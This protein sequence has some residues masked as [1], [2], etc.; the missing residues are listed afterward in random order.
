M[1][2]KSRLRML[3]KFNSLHGDPAPLLPRQM[4]L[5]DLMNLRSGV[6][7]RVEEVVKA[8]GKRH[9]KRR[10][11]EQLARALD[12]LSRDTEQLLEE[13]HFGHHHDLESG[14]YGFDG[15]RRWRDTLADALSGPLADDARGP[16]HEAA[17]RDWYIERAAYAFIA[18]GYTGLGAAATSV[19]ASWLRLLTGIL[20]FGDTDA[21]LGEIKYLNKAVGR[22]LGRTRA[23]RDQYE[24]R[25]RERILQRRSRLPAKIL[26]A[27]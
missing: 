23:E 4:I 24:A 10:E 19:F 17:V 6:S 20:G 22:V 5:D 7:Q 14:G 8:T 13:Q 25:L 27:F 9:L 11:V 15:L 18:S 26:Q 16:G 2:P 1:I 12:G 3:D 21:G